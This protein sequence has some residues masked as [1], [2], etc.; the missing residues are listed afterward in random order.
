MA[1]RSPQAEQAF[2]SDSAAAVRALQLVQV[3]ELSLSAHDDLDI[4]HAG[5]IQTTK[6][7][8]PGYRVPGY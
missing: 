6:K 2:D 7:V 5:T 3:G 1:M 8:V 4:N